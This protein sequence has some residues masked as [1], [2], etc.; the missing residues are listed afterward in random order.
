MTLSPGLWIPVGL[1]ATS[2]IAQIAVLFLINRKKLRA[3]FRFFFAYNIAAVLMCAT[4]IAG[5]IRSCCVGDGYVYLFWTLNALLM[6]LEFTVM[7][8]IFANT[9]KP[10]SA[11][12]DLG[13]MMFRWVALFLLIGATVTAFATVGA[14]STKIMAAVALVERSM[15]LMQCGLL[16]LFFLFERRL[17]LSWRS[18]NV[19]IAVG[20]GASA[21]CGLIIAYLREHFTAASYSLGILDNA[22]YLVIV[23]F[24]AVCFA[25]P[26]PERKTA[27]DCPS[28]LIFQRWNESLMATPFVDRTATVASVESFLPGIEKTVDRVMAR[29]AV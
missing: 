4:A 1:A 7:Y 10:Y 13:K 12:I 11:L 25:L 9:V 28:K 2:A 24:W 8:E 3:D 6:A 5:Y 18:P 17:G 26:E 15:R 20:L 14:E 23:G 21:S 27:M 19:S 16:L 29:K 22:S